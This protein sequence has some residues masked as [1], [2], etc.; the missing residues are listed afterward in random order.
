MANN[1]NLF[2]VENIPTADWV[3]WEK[4]GDLCKWTF[5]Q[6]F[7]KQGSWTL[8]DQ[9]VYVLQRA[10]RWHGS[11]VNRVITN[12]VMENIDTLNVWIKASNNYINNRLKNL[13]EWDIVGFAFMEEIP[14]KT[15]GMNPAKSIQ[16]FVG[17]V[18]Q[19]YLDNKNNIDIDE[20]NKVFE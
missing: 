6:K 2:A 14:A 13:K 4:V 5:V 8:P 10:S 12:P 1:D 11:V 16:C 20:M 17:W 18:D 19:D 3:K 7:N 15:K 9:I